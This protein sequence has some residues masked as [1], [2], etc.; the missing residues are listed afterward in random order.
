MN[1]DRLAEIREYMDHARKHLPDI[2]PTMG[3]EG[4]MLRDLLL[5]YDEQVERATIEG[6]Y[7]RLW[8]D[9][10]LVLEAEKRSGAWK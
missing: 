2:Y 8:M 4:G 6:S 7:R 1:K 5:A 9:R 10:C 3:G